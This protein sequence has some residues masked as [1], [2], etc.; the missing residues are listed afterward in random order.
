MTTTGQQIV[1]L[2]REEA[3]Q[4]QPNW[5]VFQ[6]EANARRAYPVHYFCDNEEGVCNRN[7]YTVCIY[8]GAWYRV[9][10]DP[11][12]GEPVLGEPALEIHAYD[13]EDQG[14]HSELDS[15][16]EQQQDPIDKEIRHSPIHI[17]PARMTMAMSVTRTQLA[18]MVQ[19]G[20]GS[21]PPSRPG[22]PPTTLASLQNRLN[23]A[24]R[25]TGLPGGDSPGGPGGPRGPGGPGAPGG[26]A[27][28]QQAVPQQLIIPAGDVKTM[29]QLPQVFTR[30]HAQ[31]NNFIKEVKWYLQL[32][33][34]MARF[35]SPIKKIMFTLTLIK[36]P[37]TAGWTCDMGD[38]LDGLQLADNIPDLWMQF[39]EEFGQQFQ[40]M[41][42]ED[43]AR[44]QMEGLWMK[45]PDIDGYITKF[46]ELAWQAG[47][48][49]G[50]AENMHTFIKGLM[51][52][53]MEEVLKP[54]LVQGYHTVKQKAIKC[55]RSKVLMENI[56]KAR[57][58]GGRGALGNVFQGFQRGGPPW[59]PFYS[60][61]EG[62][63]QQGLP[64]RYTSS[65]TPPWMNNTP[66]PMDVG[67]NRAPMY[68]GRGAGAR[69]A[70][71]PPWG[72]LGQCETCY[73]CRRIGHFV[74]ECPHGATSHI[75]QVQD[76]DSTGW[77]DYKLEGM[78]APSVALTN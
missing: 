8:H 58:L 35:D 34:D 9:K 59:Q 67:R 74:R 66:V 28:P 63:N 7:T 11:T 53:V 70:N 22:M 10:L 37:D 48:T 1:P 54:P 40:D 2:T 29:G 55:T 31:A 30:N 17:S 32:N 16:N 68:Q 6:F 57:Q 60:R 52:S 12:T 3:L 24:L 78:T 56:L 65:N 47:Y 38:F 44:V 72:R 15:D 45:F 61:Q 20:R 4:G 23:A 49:A 18:I 43:H 36:G 26:Q 19:V 21:A 69:W 73:N 41:Q 25:Q 76:D 27:G 42:K 51:P 5:W 33:Q 50:S 62:Q 39:L 75:Q 46:K 13:I 64:S 14:G 71:A 77:N